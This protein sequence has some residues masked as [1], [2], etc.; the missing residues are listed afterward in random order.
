MLSFFVRNCKNL[1]V[2]VACGQFRT[3][4][5][6]NCVFLLFDRSQPIIETSSGMKF[7]C[8]SF[9]SYPEL[10]AQFQ[11]AK[12][13]LFN[14]Q[15]SLIYDF[16]KPTSDNWSFLPSNVNHT[17]V[18]STIPDYI[19][20]TG[21]SLVPI[22]LGRASFDR[23]CLVLIFLDGVKV[24]EPAAI[25]FA[26]AAA[27]AEN[28][29]IV[30]MKIV[31]GKSREV[32]EAL[33]RSPADLAQATAAPSVVGIEISGLNCEERVRHIAKSVDLPQSALHVSEGP[34]N[35]AAEIGKFFDVNKAFRM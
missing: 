18:F 19:H 28:M 14:N 16:N 30:Q 2:I 25:A 17:H 13:N 27:A 34:E 20:A 21:P 33:T 15:W 11:A 12:M 26:N 8:F 35:A 29:G 4:D 24:S 31:E 6:E 32:Q 5:C 9:P 7:G 22:T 23:S 10:A 3:R 1:K